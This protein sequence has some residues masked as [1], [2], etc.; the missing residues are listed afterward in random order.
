MNKFVLA[1]CSLGFIASASAQVKA[2]DAD[3][4]QVRQQFSS[5]NLT[6]KAVAESPMEGLLQVFTDKGLFFTS[7]DGQYFI[8]GNIYDL[9]NKVLVNDE[10]MRPYIQQQVDAQKSG[11]IEY[12]AT[13]EKYVINV[14]TDPTCGYC[15]KLHNEMKDYNNAGITV[16]YLAFP[17]AGAN[18]ASAAKLASVAG[19]GDKA[20]T[21]AQAMAMGGAP[22]NVIV[23]LVDLRTTVPSVADVKRIS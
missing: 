15:R 11:V 13:N 23:S 19:G 22:V 10:Q 5:L 7:K 1:F 12:K 16:R 4:A 8:E 18:S 17:R 20:A 21:A 2:P 9:T 6:V 3:Y 14:F